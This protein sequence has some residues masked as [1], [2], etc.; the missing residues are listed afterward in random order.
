[1]V[2]IEKIHS[3]FPLLKVNDL[4]IDSHTAI[5]GPSG[6]GKTTFLRCLVGV[7]PYDGSIIIDNQSIDGKNGDA[8]TVL[9][10][11]CA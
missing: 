10:S 9:W 6:A 3:N 2:R 8:R 5:I 11:G 4:V 7:H 1:M